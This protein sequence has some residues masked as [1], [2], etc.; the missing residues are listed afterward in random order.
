ML[1]PQEI[2]VRYVALWNEPDAAKRRR[3]IE[4]FFT[5]NAEHYVSNR[6]AIGYDALEA[7][8]IGS[9]QKNVRDS[10]YSFRA[11]QGAQK[12]RNMVIFDWEMTPADNPDTVLFVGR[13]V[14]TLDGEERALSDF[15]FTVA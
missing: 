6:E 9:H 12:L 7:R 1:T 11:V 10:G 13:E 14:I 15:M 2:A 5:P 4:S 3:A 8:I